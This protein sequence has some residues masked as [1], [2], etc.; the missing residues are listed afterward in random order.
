[1]MLSALEKEIDSIDLELFRLIRRA[2]EL[3]LKGIELAKAIRSAR[4]ISF[5][6]LPLERQRACAGGLE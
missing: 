5:T 4:R 3:G 6:M 2:D 1:M